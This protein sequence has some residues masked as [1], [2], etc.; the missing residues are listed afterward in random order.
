MENNSNLP[1][2]KKS[3]EG[4]SRDV[5]KLKKLE[6]ISEG[7]YKG[8]LI[9][10]LDK[11]AGRIIVDGVE[12][13]KTNIKIDKYTNLSDNSEYAKNVKKFLRLLGLSDTS[14]SKIYKTSRNSQV[15]GIKL[16]FNKNSDLNRDFTEFD[17]KSTIKKMKEQLS[18]AY[19][20]EI[21]HSNKY[22]DFTETQR[23]AQLMSSIY[24]GKIWK[25]DLDYFDEMNEETIRDFS[26][27]QSFHYTELK[28]YDDQNNDI[29]S[30]YTELLKNALKC[31]IAYSGI[32]FAELESL[33]KLSE[34]KSVLDESNIYIVTSKETYLNNINSNFIDEYERYKKGN[35]K[36]QETITGTGDG[37]Q[38]E[39]VINGI[40]AM[41]L[42]SYCLIIDSLDNDLT[43]DLFYISKKKYT[44]MGKTYYDESSATR[45]ISVKGLK[46]TNAKI[47]ASYLSQYTDFRIEQVKKKTKFLGIGGFVGKVL[48][49]IFNLIMQGIQLIAKVLYYIP[50][51]RLEIQF[52]AWIF[53]GKWSND[54]DRFVMFASRIV[55]AIIAILIVVYTGGGGIQ[56]ALSLLASSYGMYTGIKEFDEA[57][58]IAKTYSRNNSN[59]EEATNKLNEKLIDLSNSKDGIE[60]K[61]NALYK[62]FDAINNI[63]RSPFEKGGLYSKK[64]S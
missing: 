51:F 56:I 18:N 17:F 62:P 64:S 47:I 42:W 25:E 37:A 14:L 13:Y 19:K 8:Q 32:N 9:Q 39:Y 50:V 10:L 58:E 34:E 33:T 53:S 29:T 26:I 28:I 38:E 63:Y 21:I 59:T 48:G 44:F 23:N 7:W 45:Y 15:S 52:I 6:V 35:I 31:C 61:N 5:L 1:M 54:R 49:G 60:A 46:R 24:I 3:G 36:V 11:I 22:Y 43:N 16:H 27:E 4:L 2:F 12:C 55:L 20:F 40:L 30:G 57:K 41:H